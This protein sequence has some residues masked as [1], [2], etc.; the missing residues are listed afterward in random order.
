MFYNFGPWWQKLEVYSSYKMKSE[1]FIINF[2]A[3]IFA[4]NFLARNVFGAKNF[5]GK[6]FGGKAHFLL[7]CVMF[8]Q[9]DIFCFV[10]TS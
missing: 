10:L 7:Y 1:N 3:K 8:E 2:G 4:R 9:P 5:G 6:N